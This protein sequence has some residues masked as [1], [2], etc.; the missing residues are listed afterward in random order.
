VLRR[1]GDEQGLCR[2]FRLQALLHWFA[3]RT[4]AAASAWEQA[5]VHAM[6]AGAEHE[7][8]DILGWLASSLVYGPAP[9]AD[10]IVRC[11]E[12]AVEVQ[13]NLVAHASTL[14]KLAALHAM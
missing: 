6:G 7:R 12:I 11:E 10:G 2:A 5:A 1:H 13:G 9:V 14:P 4:G 3:A 8:A